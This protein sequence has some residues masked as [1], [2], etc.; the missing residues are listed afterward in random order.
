MSEDEKIDDTVSEN[1]YE[2]TFGRGKMIDNPLRPYYYFVN[3]LF[4][5]P[6]TWI[7]KNF[8]LKFRGPEYPYY[9]QR[10]RRVPSIDQCYTDDAACVWEANEQFKRDRLV[11]RHILILLRNRMAQCVFYNREVNEFHN[12]DF[13]C[14][15][16]KKDL[17]DAELNY[18]IKC[19]KFVVK[20][21]QIHLIF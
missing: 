19:I 11:D 17:K 20:S 12:F 15:K 4:D 13:L 7:R 1:F 6:V 21:F 18:F 10:F 16:E 3:N 5:G 8:V 2:E 14:P 9:H